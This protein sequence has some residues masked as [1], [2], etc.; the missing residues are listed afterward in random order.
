[1]QDANHKPEMAI[2]LTPF[3]AL[4]GFLPLTK[5]ATYLDSS[6]EFA[7]LIPPTI[8]GNFVAISTSPNPSGPAEK[9]ALKDL[10]SAMMTA[11]AAL[12]T[13]E[14]DKLVQRYTNGGETEAERDI[15]EL[16]LTLYTQFPGDIGVFCAFVLN[17]VK[18]EPGEAI[19]LSAGEPHA[20]ISGGKLHPYRRCQISQIPGQTSWKPWLLPIM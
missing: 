2:A 13:T 1:M 16:V 20:Y 17:Y 10:F 5:I 14:L 6:P 7:A 18:M 8:A 12:F 9:A 11:E 4:C 3:T 15:K 19:F